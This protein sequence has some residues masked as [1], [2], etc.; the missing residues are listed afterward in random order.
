MSAGLCPR[1]MPT[2]S[3]TSRGSSSTSRPSDCAFQCIM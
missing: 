1:L 3:F 2:T